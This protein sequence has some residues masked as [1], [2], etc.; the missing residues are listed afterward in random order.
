MLCSLPP[1]VQGTTQP[2][3]LSILTSFNGYFLN[4]SYIL[5]LVT[6]E[7]STSLHLWGLL[8]PR[9]MVGNPLSART[10]LCSKHLI[11]TYNGAIISPPEPCHLPRTC[12]WLTVRPT[13]LKRS[14]AESERKVT[15]QEDRSQ[16]SG[17][18][19]QESQ[20]PRPRDGEANQQR[21]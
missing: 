10:S 14:S 12:G 19:H 9:K 17:A 4:T 2:L 20:R 13:V 5:C 16:R 3:S 6:A 7:S 1:S 11:C 21:G 8:F 18:S 15:T